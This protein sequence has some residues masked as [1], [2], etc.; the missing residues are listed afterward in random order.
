[1]AG[2][3]VP[4]VFAAVVVMSGVLTIQPAWADATT[5]VGTHVGETF[6]GDVVV[7]SG[8]R[9]TLRGSTVNGN[10][11][12]SAG[13]FL[14]VTGSTVTGNVVADGAAVQTNGAAGPVRI[15]GNVSITH[16][17]EFQTSPTSFAVQVVLCATDIGGSLVVEGASGRGPIG[18]GGPFCTGAIGGPNHIGGTF[19]LDQ[20]APVGGPID[21][22]GNT[23]GSALA[24]FANTPAPSGSGN[25]AAAKLG[26]CASL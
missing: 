22:S 3:R 1:M 9:C 25:T 10:L 17:K 23:V 7:P 15:G 21:V 12:A 20:N 8:Q 19:L 11:T 5:C 6:T 26:Q 4:A 2:R 13:S 24:C 16:A 14:L 18:V